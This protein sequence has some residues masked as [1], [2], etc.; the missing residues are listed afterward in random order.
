MSSNQLASRELFELPQES[1]SSLEDFR[2]GVAR[3]WEGGGGGELSI[4]YGV[5]EGTKQDV[6]NEF[7]S[8]GW[9]RSGEL[10]TITRLKLDY[11]EDRT[12]MGYVGFNINEGYFQFYTNQSKTKEIDDGISKF[13][14]TATNITYLYIRPTALLT[15]AETMYE[16]IDEDNVITEFIA[17]SPNETFNHYGVNGYDRL[18]TLNEQYGV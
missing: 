10:G 7:Q 3:A 8:H 1:Y 2:E 4:I 16:D 12:A 6:L 9:E 14:N 17:K 11:A 15:L 18:Q 5:Y 13:L